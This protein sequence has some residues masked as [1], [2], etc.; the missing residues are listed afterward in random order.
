[1]AVAPLISPGEMSIL[2]DA[3]VTAGIQSRYGPFQSGFIPFL[4]ESL[5]TASRLHS[6]GMQRLQP[7]RKLT[8]S[9]SQSV[10]LM[11]GAP[12]LS[13]RFENLCTLLISS[14]KD[15]PGLIQRLLS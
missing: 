4:V 14:I 10:K 7:T 11:L 12:G 6:S 15:V 2:S 8:S 5:N 13:P 9:K 1:M 3:A